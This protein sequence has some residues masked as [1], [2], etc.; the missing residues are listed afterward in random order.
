MRYL[1]IDSSLFVNNR[2]RFAKKLKQHAIAVFHSNDMMPTSADG[3]HPFVQHPDLF[4][5][6]G[7][8]QEDTVLVICP[9]AQEKT[10][11][12]VLFI[13][14]TSDDIAIWEG[15]KLT[16]EQGTSISGIRTVYW[17]EDFQKIFRSLVL[18]SERIYLNTN[19][20]ARADVTVE[21]RDIRFLKWCREAYPL[22]Q[23]ERLAPIMQ[24]LRSIKSVMETE[25]IKEACKIAEKAFRRVLKIVK[26][27]IREF[28]VE[29]E[30]VHEL[31]RN[32]SRGPAFPSIIAS[33]LNSCIL[34]Y[35][36]NSRQCRKGDVLLIDFGA[37]YANYAS[38]VTRTIP[39]SGKFSKRQRQ[40]YEAVHRI[41]KQAIQMLIPGNTF[42]HYHKEVGKIVEKELI[43]L[44]L[45]TSKDISREDDEKPPYKKY[46]MHGISH[47][48]GLA[49]HDLGDRHRAFE[50]GMVL[51]CEPGIYL[52]EEKIGVRIENDIL[53]T[54][55][56]PVDLT[57]N[58]PSDPSEI[59]DIMNS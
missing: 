52:R 35:I 56:G 27:G 51:T 53:I 4:Y 6:C 46:F 9:D 44:G 58:I 11:R 13:R 19:E 3:T 2:E 23:Y 1:P 10:H 38:D 14:K 12:E 50:S 57:R 8:D 37:E 21:S 33:G 25:L 54:E 28:E 16:R 7:I 36:E 59:E 45:L 18:E 32:R 47:H 22:H 20:H 39:V 34:H 29:A 24:D 40:I 55:K 31:I 5:L 30:I 41:Q 26:P 15:N 42:Y 49:V 43:Q 48:L 17:V